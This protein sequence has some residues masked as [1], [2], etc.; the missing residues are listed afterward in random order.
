M[1][2]KRKLK[3]RHLIYY[4]SVFE[5]NTD[6][7]VGQLVDLTTDGLMLT[8]ENPMEIGAK[9]KLRMVLPEEIRG[10]TNLFFEAVAK[11][12]KRDINPNFYDI[13][14]KVQNISKT[15]AKII[16]TLIQGFSFLDYDG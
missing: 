2:E 5:G 12:C 10:K 8:S 11:W 14:F 13:G 9:L 4:L 16:E 1:V 6:H 15:E 7:L 3:R